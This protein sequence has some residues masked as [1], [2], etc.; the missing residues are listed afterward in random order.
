MRWNMAS[1]RHFFNDSNRQ[2]STCALK[3]HFCQKGRSSV[4]ILVSWTKKVVVLNSK[5]FELVEYSNSSLVWNV[6]GWRQCGGRN[7]PPPPPPSSRICKSGLPSQCE[8]VRDA[9][10]NRGSK[11]CAPR[12]AAE[13]PSFGRV[14]HAACG[15]PR[16]TELEA[17]RFSTRFAI[18]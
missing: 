14:C 18:Q 10:R 12:T 1:L 6:R 3:G 8:W 2:W 5:I 11:S 16:I 13:S 4:E 9:N 15:S 17:R 7:H